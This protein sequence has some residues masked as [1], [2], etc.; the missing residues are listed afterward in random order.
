[1][2][3][4]Q[5]TALPT[6]RFA[7]TIVQRA[8]QAVTLGSFANTLFLFYVYMHIKKLEVSVFKHHFGRC[9]LET[10]KEKQPHFL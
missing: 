2:R 4:K 3:R 6:R 1:M 5:A 9:L 7:T 8:S 10:H